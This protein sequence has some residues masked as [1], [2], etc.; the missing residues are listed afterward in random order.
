M[1]E[2]PEVEE[3][4]GEGWKIVEFSNWASV[5]G[6]PARAR[7]TLAICIN[8]SGNRTYKWNEQ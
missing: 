4:E 7:C 6:V 5:S 3:E 1:L 2:T 8:K